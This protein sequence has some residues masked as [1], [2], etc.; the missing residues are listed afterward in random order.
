M[1]FKNKT[2][3]ELYIASC[4]STFIKEMNESNDI[5]NLLDV[6]RRILGQPLMLVDI[7]MCFIA[8]SGGESVKDEPFWDWILTNGY[9]KEEYTNLIMEDDISTEEKFVWEYGMENHRQ[10]VA[11]I[12]QGHTTLGYLKLL[13]YN[14]PITDIE[15]EILGNLSNLI[16]ILMSTSSIKYKFANSRVE[17][18]LESLVERKTA[19]ASDIE[20][21]FSALNIRLL[22]RLFIIAIEPISKTE[23]PVEQLYLL[24]R[25]LHNLLNRPTVFIYQNR[26][27]VLFDTSANTFE[28]DYNYAPLKSLLKEYK[29]QAGVSTQF[30]ELSLVADEYLN[31]MSS[32]SLAKSIG[33]KDTFIFFSKH[34]LDQ[35]ILTYS[36]EHNIKYLVHPA[37]IQ[38]DQIDKE[39]NS[40]YVMSLLSYIRYG[41]NLTN[42]AKE[43]HIHHNTLKYRIAKI[44]EITNI[45]LTDYDLCYHLYLS[46]RVWELQ[47]NILRK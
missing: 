29:L 24:K 46:G 17:A 10:L 4:T 15:K 25:K 13:E 42:T 8:Q 44:V 45:D 5:Q 7:S 20:E 3:E 33:L 32:L 47:K 11:K 35:L 2:E 30:T 27:I 9:V 31:A 26:L 19:D 21:R 41:Q 28:K 36:R 38:L 23:L 18:F 14:H 1:E 6:G 39:K 43:L 16:A 34:I 12:I 22:E 40:E 37:I